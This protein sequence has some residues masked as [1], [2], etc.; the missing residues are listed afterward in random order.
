[1][2]LIIN[3]SYRLAMAA[4]AGDVEPFARFIEEGGELGLNARKFL[5]QHL[6]GE[7]KRQRGNPRIAA[8]AERRLRAVN[9]IRATQIAMNCS[10]YAAIKVYLQF[11]KRANR[12]TVRSWLKRSPTRVHK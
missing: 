5:A 12:D 4:W 7:I 11:N 1:M 10:E 8:D 6:R 3:K 9:Q 2:P